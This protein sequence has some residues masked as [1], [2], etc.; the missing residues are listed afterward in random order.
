DISDGATAAPVAP[1]IDLAA[2]ADI[3]PADAGSVA[4]TVST[5]DPAPQTA[6]PIAQVSTP[7]SQ[8][9]EEP[10]VAETGSAPAMPDVAS[11]DPAG[12]APVATVTEPVAAPAIEPEPETR[13]AQA[14]ATLPEIAPL[15]PGQTPTTEIGNAS[16]PQPGFSETI[17]GVKIN[18][19]P[20]IGDPA[21]DGP[22]TD[23]SGS[24]VAEDAAPEDPATLP[25]VLRYALNTEIAPGQPIFAVV[26]LDVGQANGG[27]EPGALA[28]LALPVTIAVSPT[29]T[30]A[31]TR[32]EEYRR[33]G[34]E[35]AI[36]APQLPE[37]ANATDM[38]VSYQS[39]VSTLPET[40]ALIGQPDAQ[41]Q[42]DRRA[43]EHLAALL[44]A[45]GRG[46]VSY[47][48]GLD[49]AGQAAEKE[50]IPHSAIYRV[51]DADH[52]SAAKISRYLDRAAFEA[53]QNGLVL[54]VGHS[55]PETIVALQDWAA[56]GAKGT[57]IAPVTAA[58]MAGRPLN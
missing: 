17:P 41:F 40:V 58:M 39:Y 54:V 38:E 37:G 19:L 30:D 43:A 5:L 26:I 4:G 29:D 25:P 42:T 31:A 9:V 20:S 3:A 23:E 28:A 36:L 22:V 45:D 21:T 32:A 33:A 13:I 55:Y 53:E 51:L 44:A 12:L 1:E 47:A 35:V 14:Q 7:E 27:L 10:V 49:P 8:P 24:S 52:E 34:L 46:L 57:V 2:L 50:G 48:R 16:A 18:R 15:V 56:A 11:G 6:A